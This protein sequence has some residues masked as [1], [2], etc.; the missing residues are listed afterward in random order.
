M[1]P[2]EQKPKTS[3]PDIVEQAKAITAYRRSRCYTDGEA[4]LAM[5]WLRG[6]ITMSQVHKVLRPGAR[7]NFSGTILY[8]FAQVFRDAYKNGKLVEAGK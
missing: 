1:K 2:T 8:R 7:S 4:A 5:A 3:E 6:E